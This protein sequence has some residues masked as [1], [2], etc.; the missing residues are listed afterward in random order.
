MLGV[1]ISEQA[2]SLQVK[3]NVQTL[4]YKSPMTDIIHTNGN[5]MDQLTSFKNSPE[6]KK[7]QNLKLLTLVKEFPVFTAAHWLFRSTQLSLHLWPWSRSRPGSQSF[8]EKSVCAHD[9][10]RLKQ[11]QWVHGKVRSEHKPESEVKSPQG[12]NVDT[13]SSSAAAASQYVL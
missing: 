9:R 5:I 7:Q 11:S 12:L 1:T 6:Q 4:Q 10:R 8:P 13:N 3:G 2:A